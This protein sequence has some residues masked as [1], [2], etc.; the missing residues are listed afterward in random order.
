MPINSVEIICL[1]CP[2][3]EFVEK[4]IREAI[5]TIEIE[6][7]IKIPFEFKHTANLREISKYSLN[8][9][10]T[11]TVLINGSVE[12]AGKIEPLL[13]KKRLDLIHKGY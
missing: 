6:N 4:K 2:K 8:P 1:P 5:K 3:C 12:F 7:K 9:S 11:P 10:Q 13:V